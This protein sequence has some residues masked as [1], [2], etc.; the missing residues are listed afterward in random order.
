MLKKITATLLVAIML[1]CSAPS[2]LSAKKEEN[3]S[4]INIYE[5]WGNFDTPEAVNMS[6]IYNSGGGNLSFSDKGADKLVCSRI[7]S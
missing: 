2:V 7:T 1:V 3:K 6:R 5:L 4:A